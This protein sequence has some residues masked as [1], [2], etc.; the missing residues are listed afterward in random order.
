MNDSTSLVQAVTGQGMGRPVAIGPKCTDK[1][2][3]Y[4]LDLGG[5]RSK[6]DPQVGLSRREGFCEMSTPLPP[7]TFN[8][9]RNRSS[10]TTEARPLPRHSAQSGS[11]NYTST[12]SGPKPDR[13]ESFD[14]DSSTCLS[15]ISIFLPAFNCCSTDNFSYDEASPISA[16]RSPPFTAISSVPHTTRTPARQSEPRTL[17]SLSSR[18]FQTCGRIKTPIVVT[19]HV[20]T[21]TTASRFNGP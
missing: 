17:P 13:S 15:V 21:P 8:S 2:V 10:S 4:P 11:V 14:S 19:A 6:A 1:E 3:T 7:R 9:S 18:R 16:P 12:N 20:C 5:R